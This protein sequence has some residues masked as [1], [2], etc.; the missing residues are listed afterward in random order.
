MTTMDD[1]MRGGPARVRY[2]LDVPALEASHGAPLGPLLVALTELAMRLEPFGP[3]SAFEAVNLHLLYPVEP[4]P[5][6]TPA[7]GMSLLPLFETGVDCH[8]FG[9][10]E[11]A[12][13]P[14]DQRPIY[15]VSHEDREVAPNLATFLGLV[16]C[17]DAEFLASDPTPDELRAARKERMEDRAF[18]S[19]SKALC[20][21]PGVSVPKLG[22][23][24]PAPKA[25]SVASSEPNTVGLPRVAQLARAG[26][27]TAARKELL[28]QIQICLDLGDLV[29]PD[30]WPDLQ[31]LVDQLHPTLPV[32]SRLG[33]EARGIRLAAV[34]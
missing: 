6:L 31:R 19:A 22:R 17:A 26:Q 34:P 16:A 15:L 9:V 25:R 5:E 21:L 10:S 4:L 29:A 32:A 28:K 3:C 30:K 1:I 33:L 2:R 24:V 13:G 8:W 20:K 7:N 27:V 23:E 18:A 12:S 14:L 11:D